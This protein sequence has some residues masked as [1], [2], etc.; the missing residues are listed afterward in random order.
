M[1]LFMAIPKGLVQGASIIFLVFVIGGCFQI[2]NDTGAL[3]GSIDKLVKKFGNKSY[4][5]LPIVMALMSV[6]GALGI[7]V[8]TTIAVIPLGMAL[9][10]KLK[11]DSLVALSVMYLGA[12]AGF[13]S[14]PFC[15]ATVQLAQNIAGLTPLSGLG[16]RVVVCTIITIVTIAFTVRYARKVQK[17]KNNSL[18]ENFEWGEVEEKHIEYT[19]KHS[20]II[21]GVLVAF[22]VYAYGAF[23]LGWGNEHMSA[24]MLVSAI[25]SVIITRMDPNKAAQSFIKGCKDMV[26]GALIVGVATAISIVLTEGNVIHTII[27]AIS[28]PLASLPSVLSAEFML[29]INLIFNFFV[30]SGSGQAAVVMPIMAPMADVI[31]ITR[32][33]AVLAYQ[34]GD[35]FSNVIVPTSGV[36]MGCLGVAKVPYTKWVKFVLPLLFMWIIVGA[37]SI[38][39]AVMI[40]YA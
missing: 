17:D 32:Q 7:V 34:Y 16:L 36:L 38:A 12:Y 11:T 25:F 21:I 9:A 6:L 29:L 13:C 20:V 26:S 39:V 31:G 37:I 18:I 10:K 33:V 3:E 28:E 19:W 2:I 35:G 4:L 27:H 5:V 14:S 1:Q 8:V 22:T 24:M 15:A 40:G 23:N 30:P